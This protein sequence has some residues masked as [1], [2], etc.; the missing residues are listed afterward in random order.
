MRLEKIFATG[1]S[2]AAAT[3]AEALW[4]Q[5]GAVVAAAAAAWL[6]RQRDG[7]GNDVRA[8]D[9]SNMMAVEAA[10]W[11]WQLGGGTVAVTEA[12]QRRWQYGSG[13]TVAMTKVAAACSNGGGNGDRVAVTAFLRCTRL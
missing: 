7:S 11:V 12:W 13:S 4:C 5:L 10:A 6:Q 3:V 8:C 9:S 1:G 2:L